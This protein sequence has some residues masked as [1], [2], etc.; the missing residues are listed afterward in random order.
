MG[1]RKLN[2]AIKATQEKPPLRRLTFFN[3]YRRS[4]YRHPD[5][6]APFPP[7]WR[8]HEQAVTFYILL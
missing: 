7:P 5:E 3:K 4:M 2:N 6:F 1:R 8:N